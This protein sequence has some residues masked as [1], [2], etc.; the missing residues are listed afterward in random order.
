[1]SGEV[2]QRLRLGVNYTPRRG[3][4]HHWLDFDVGA[5]REDFAAIAGLGLDHV[6]VFGL[7]PVFQPN[8]GLIRPAALAQL[9][10]LVD[11]AADAG[12]DVAVDVLQGHLSSFDFVP[13]WAYS[14]HQRNL[15]TDGAVVAAQEELV[16]AV[17][18]TLAG[19]SAFIGIGVGNET[20]QFSHP[21]HPDPSVVSAQQVDAWLTRLL[22]AATDAMPRGLHQHSFDDRVW[23][24]ERST[25]TPHHA[26][27]FGGVTTVHSWVFMG[28]AQHYG[29]GHPAL[30]LL[31]TYLV[32]LAVAWAADPARPVWLQEVGA[33]APS[34]PAA[35]AA[36]FLE[37][38]VR[39][40]TAATS[41]WGVTWWCSHDVD[42]SLLDFPELE[43]TLGLFSA[44][45]E[46]KPAADRLAAVAADLRAS[47]PAPPASRVAVV[48]DADVD[49][50]GSTAPGSAAFDAWLR[51][52]LDGEHP[53]IVRRA[54]LDE[55]GYLAR[56]A[57]DR[58][59]PGTE[60][61]PRSGQG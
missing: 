6:R 19:H 58:L 14:W 4:F 47:P 17:G 38:T 24:D 11:A 21:S 20:N 13:S 52:A 28:A 41:L 56:R 31:A 44:A 25:V 54:R 53:A 8:R 12:L 29:T 59:T 23:F 15:F 51:L 49:T 46:R 50:R 45:G 27:S 16:R 43:Y 5:V 60:R 3:W 9:V 55:P 1:M 35:A 26:T 61:R 37:R 30:E 48:I 32:E 42:R 7:W 57:I 39:R 33:P 2:P 34:V 40:A 22:G 18:R 36:D 10:Q